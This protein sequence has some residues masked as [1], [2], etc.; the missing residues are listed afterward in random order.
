MCRTW[1]TLCVSWL[2]ALQNTLLSARCW[3]LERRLFYLFGLALGTSFTFAALVRLSGFL[4]GVEL[5]QKTDFSAVL[6]VSFFHEKAL[7]SFNIPFL[8]DFLFICLTLSEWWEQWTWVLVFTE[9]TRSIWQG[10]NGFHRLVMFL[11][12][13]LT[14]SHSHSLQVDALFPLT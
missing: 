11:P 13:I 1:W 9:E 12:D 5:G 3:Q 7:A 6:F 2:P 4:Q 14:H 10:Q 8:V